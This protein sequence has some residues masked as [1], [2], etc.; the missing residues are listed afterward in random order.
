MENYFIFSRFDNNLDEYI[1]HYEVYRL[2]VLDTY[3]LEGSWID[4]EKKSN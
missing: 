4:L 1:D 3:E 2:P